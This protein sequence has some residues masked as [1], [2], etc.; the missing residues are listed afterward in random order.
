[1][2]DLDQKRAERF[3]ATERQFKILGEV[4]TVKQGVQPEVML[5]WEAVSETPTGQEA[6][7]AMDQIVLDVLVPD[8][9]LRWVELR[10]QD[11]DEAIDLIDLEDLVPALIEIATARPFDKSASSGPASVTPPTGTPSTG[12]SDSKPEKVLTASR[13]GAS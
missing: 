4:F 2:L 3:A 9:R 8:D 5:A 10:K 13:S 7:E 12:T 11:T 1:M 6:M